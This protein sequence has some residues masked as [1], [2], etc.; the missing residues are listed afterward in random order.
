VPHAQRNSRN[1]FSAPPALMSARL[2]TRR[3][4]T[5][6]DKG[7]RAHSAAAPKMTKT[8]KEMRL[9]QT[10][11]KGLFRRACP[12]C[13]QRDISWLAVDLSGLWEVS[14]E[15][16]SKIRSLLRSSYPRDHKQIEDLLMELRV[17]WLSQ[18]ADHLQTL[19]QILPRLQRT[20]PDSSRRRVDH[21]YRAPA[22]HQPKPGR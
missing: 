21:P 11:L 20:I 12:R 16:Q 13:R 8:Q 15:H 6:I 14:K 19:R 1:N 10:K 17:T 7:G 3:S 2:G 4:R 18:A 5:T 9:I 22:R